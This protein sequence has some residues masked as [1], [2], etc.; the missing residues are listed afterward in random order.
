MKINSRMKKRISRILLIS[1]LIASGFL[2]PIQ[3]ANAVITL[4]PKG[5]SQELW[6]A[7]QEIVVANVDGAERNIRW[8]ASPSFYIAGNPTNADNS[9][10][11]STLGVISQYCAN[12][13]PNISTNEPYYGVVFQYVPEDKFANYIPSI[14]ANTKSS[15][16]LYNY[17]S[18]KG[19][20]KFTATISTE[21]SQS[22]RDV[23][24]QLRIY[25][26]MGLRGYTKNM[27]SSMFSWTFPNSG[28]ILPS[29]LDKQVL[30]LYCSTYTGTW[31]TAQQTFDAIA[32]VWTK[33]VSTPPTNL[34]IAVGEYKNQLNFS[35]IFDPSNALDNQMSGIE[36]RI[37]DS[38]GSI[39][40]SELLDVSANIFKTH[41]A[42]LSGIKDNLRYRIEAAPVNSV[43][44]GNIVKAE[45]R[46]GTQPAP[47][48]SSGWNVSDASAEL[49]DSRNAAEDA[50]NAAK[51]AIAAFQSAK[52]DCD[53]VSS[54]FDVA[55]QDL[56]DS[57]NL[58]SGCEK[59]DDR[60]SSLRSKIFA[61]D[62]ERAATTEQANTITSTANLYAENADALVAEI[63]DISD[64]LAAT[65]KLFTKLAS[66]L[67][68]LN[69]IETNILEPWTTLTDKL[70]ILPSNSQSSIKKSQN[71]KLAAN[72]VAQSQKILASRDVQIENLSEI[73]NSTKL[74]AVISGLGNLKVSPAQVSSFNKYLNAINK[75]IPAKVCQKGSLTLLASKSGKCA[76]GFELI[77]T[78]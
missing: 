33:K 57:T 38:S 13:T 44:N 15:Y 58:V 55:E 66:Q 59:L 63:Q 73:D 30:R 46:A 51:E 47:Q 42:I 32:S 27:S 34:K 67:E 1:I 69:L 25:Q 37:Y 70:A 29:E 23:D 12:I 7:Y 52:I 50:T 68:Q 19:L 9:T 65:E 60:A 77:P 31:N 71:Y 56:F 35:F 76:K 74:G 26:A 36:Y 53:S 4:P 75:V 64:S 11:R 72:Y 24:T 54:N 22:A 17:Q 48:D 28:L 43:G 78:S 45:G 41:T 2:A 21:I 14:P 8:N 39:V 16:A 20:S 3:F 49:T 5:V 18:G 62:P 6:T 61:L 40:K 10:F